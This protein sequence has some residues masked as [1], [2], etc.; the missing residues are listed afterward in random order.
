MKHLAAGNL[1]NAT[2][3]MRVALDAE[4]KIAELR[5]ADFNRSINATLNPPRGWDGI[6]AGEETPEPVN[7]H[8]P[9][10]D[11]VIP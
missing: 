7:G 6:P 2:S 5:L 11:I 9:N 8:R 3:M 10:L 1:T 4:R